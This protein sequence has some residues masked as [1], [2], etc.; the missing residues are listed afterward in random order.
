MRRAAMEP[1]ATQTPPSLQGNPKGRVQSDLDLS[2]DSANGGSFRLED[3]RAEI[4][5]TA[6]GPQGFTPQP[7]DNTISNPTFS[8][9]V[10]P[11]SQ[12]KSPA[13][14][15][16]S[17]SASLT[18]SAL[19]SGGPKPGLFCSSHFSSDSVQILQDL[20]LSRDN[21]DLS[22]VSFDSKSTPPHAAAVGAMDSP[23]LRSQRP[24]SPVMTPIALRPM[25]D[26]V[27]MLA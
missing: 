15:E 26:Q 27:R 5:A 23:V 4:V 19:E 11:D 2:V 10:K 14:T 6:S 21:S 13:F 25:P 7:R 12:F 22:N 9:V 20:S 3:L 24:K 18:P 1:I 8:D 16:S 17:Q